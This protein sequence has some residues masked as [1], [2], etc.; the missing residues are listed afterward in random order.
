MPFVLPLVVFLL[1]LSCYPDFAESLMPED[2]DPETSSRLEIGF[3]TWKYLFLIGLQVVLASGFLI[4][5]RK[6]Y[7]EHFPLR[8]SV[9]SVVVGVVGVVLWIAVCDLGLEPRLLEALGFGAT[10][11]SFNPFT[12]PDKTVLWLFLVLRFAL[13]AVFVPIIEEL[14]V[15]GWLVRWVENPNW[16]NISLKG[17]SVMAL[18]TASFYGVLAH[19]SEAI[20][21][22]LWF[23]LVTLL[24]RKTG[25]VWDC[26]VA[27]A[28]TN[29]LLGIYILKFEQWH[30]W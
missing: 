28:V 25:N 27:H 17:L 5:F 16:E 10:R 1:V 8:V 23:G 15:R 19:P 7:L 11:P 20:A 24:M 9:W 14:F 21:A 30:L 29:L 4:F 13:L 22:F 12:I 2:V 6:V 26:V 3:N 18:F